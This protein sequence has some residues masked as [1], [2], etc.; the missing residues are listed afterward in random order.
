MERSSPYSHPSLAAQDPPVPGRYQDPLPASRFLQLF[1]GLHIACLALVILTS[2]PSSFG[3]VPLPSA[4]GMFSMRYDYGLS[5][6][7]MV[8][9]GVLP[10]ALCAWLWRIQRNVRALGAKAP[11]LILLLPA[12]VALFGLSAGK[13]IASFDLRSPSLQFALVVLPL[14]GYG[15]YA[16]QQLVRASAAPAT[17]R[18]LAL[19]PLLSAWLAVVGI[20]GLVPVALKQRFLTGRYEFLAYA[21]YAQATFMLAMLLAEC[22]LVALI[23][24]MA[25]TQESTR[26]RLALGETARQG[27]ATAG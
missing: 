17:W 18:Q 14:A 15:A 7:A 2:L 6:V 23:T 25:R 26:A 3:L 8:A 11:P 13:N 24:R 20:Q 1:L 5:M 10:F 12:G 16:I 21:N 9:S 22:L 19:P 4:L 27:A